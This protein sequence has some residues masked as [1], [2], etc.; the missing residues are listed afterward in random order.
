MVLTT[1][2]MPPTIHLVRHA[3]GHHNV[4]KNGEDIHDPFLTDEGIQQAQHLCDTFAHHDE[5]DLLVASPMKRTIQTCQKAFAPAVRRGHK[6]LLMPLAQESSDQPM[7]TGSTLEDIEKAFA[8]EDILD[9]RRLEIFPYWNTNSGTFAVDDDSLIERARMLRTALKARPESNVAIVSHGS[10]AHYIVGNLD[11]SGNH[12]T[13]M[14]NNTECRSYKF[15][16]DDDGD[17]QDA[18][19]FELQ[20]SIERRPDLEKQSSGY[21]LSPKRIRK[22]SDGQIKSGGASAEGSVS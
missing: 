17:D 18:T 12:T 15:V 21:I 1:I 22:D 14:W 19:L 3:E 9:T 5:I 8:G 2:V 7:D 16:E 10:F 4:A 13:R 11:E 20:E 6:I